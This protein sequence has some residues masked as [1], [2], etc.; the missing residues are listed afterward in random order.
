M[1]RTAD[2]ILIGLFAVLLVLPFVTADFQGGAV[3]E[4]EQRYLSEAPD[5]QDP[6]NFAQSYESW[7]DDNVGG[8]SLALE[9]YSLLLYHV[10]HTSPKPN[11]LLGRDGWQFYYTDEMLDDFAGLQLPAEDLIA[12]CE[13][14]L[15]RIHSYLEDMGI[16]MICMLLPDKKTIYPEYYPMGIRHVQGETRTDM[17]DTWMLENSKLD[18]MNLRDTLL[19]YKVFG[20]LY[21]ARQD[22]GHWNPLGAYVA[23]VELC[24]HLDIPVMPLYACEVAWSTE[25]TRLNGV[26]RLTENVPVVISG[27]EATVIEDHDF[28]DRFSGLSYAHNPDD[29]RRHY[30]N[31]VTSKPS[32]LYVGDSYSVCALPYLAQYFGETTFLHFSDLDSFT[33]LVE[34]LDPDYVLFES[35]ERMLST[36]LCQNWEKVAQRIT[37]NQLDPETIR[38]LPEEGLWEAELY[39]DSCNGVL[40]RGSTELS[41]PPKEDVCTVR[42]WA[43]DPL[44]ERNAGCL[45]FEGG[46]Q[47]MIVSCDRQRKDVADQFDTTGYLWSGFLADLPNELAYAPEGMDITVVSWDGSFRYPAFHLSLKRP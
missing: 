2:R 26:I 41:V 38:S 34:E 1:K 46:G 20:Q 8:R 39:V 32:L 13:Q 43:A 9:A 16:H 30:R 12:M 4:V 7:I 22:S 23:V 15:M 11:V 33:E 36:T 24:K 47:S 5:W 35:V 42:G 21:Y 3:S 25:T 10:F 18:Y 40:T 19:N 29:F 27:Q 14:S 17:I 31:T 6:S 44:L 45:L 28:M 37:L